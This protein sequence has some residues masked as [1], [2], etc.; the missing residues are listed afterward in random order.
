MSLI[1]YLLVSTLYTTLIRIY[2]IKRVD[3]HIL[4]DILL[5]NSC[6]ALRKIRIFTYSTFCKSKSVFLYTAKIKAYR[7]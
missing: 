7:W 5:N 2:K 1:W 4:R 3:T 6:K